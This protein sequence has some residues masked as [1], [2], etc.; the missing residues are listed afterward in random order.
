MNSGGGGGGGGGHYNSRGTAS[1]ASNIS[2]G[3][4]GDKS[5]LGGL[6][7]YNTKKDS[8]E[9]GGNSLLGQGGGGFTGA[10]TPYSY[11]PQTNS[12]TP[13]FHPGST[14]GLPPTSAPYT[15]QFP[16]YQNGSGTPAG[17]YPGYQTGMQYGPQ[18]MFYGPPPPPPPPPGQ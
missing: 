11:N 18:Q 15:Q 8:S 4:G 17:G 7:K 5:Y 9:T 14:A 1:A 12:I 6:G 10:A 13:N 3:E 16:T 2:W